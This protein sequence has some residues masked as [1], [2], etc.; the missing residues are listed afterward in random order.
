MFSN[1]YRSIL[2]QVINYGFIF[3]KDLEKERKK[4]NTLLML[5]GTEKVNLEFPSIIFYS[6]TFL[7]SIPFKRNK[8]ESDC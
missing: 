2:W 8:E 7:L 1:H 5:D 6:T 3:L 4:K